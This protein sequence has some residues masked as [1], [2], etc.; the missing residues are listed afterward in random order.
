V[1]YAEPCFFPKGE[2]SE[3]RVLD[4]GGGYVVARQYAVGSQGLLRHEIGHLLGL[5]LLAGREED[6]MTA[7]KH[8]EYFTGARAVEA[9]RAGGGDAGLP[10]VPLQKGG[11]HW[12]GE[13]VGYELMGPFGGW[14][15][16]A[17]S[18][19][20]LVD[21]GYTVDLSKALPWPWSE[22]AMAR[23]IAQELQELGADVQDVVLGEPRVFVERRP[24]DPPR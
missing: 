16:N 22:R 8:G 21:R 4:P 23:T 11:A 19:G 10:G 5:V 17:I 13:L 3:G 12:H 7:T 1:G 18:L 9:F 6:L 15:A 24:R 2:G 14:D 20:A